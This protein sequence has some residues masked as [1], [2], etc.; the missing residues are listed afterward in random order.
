MPNPSRP[1]NSTTVV[2]SQRPA[3]RLNVIA[4]PSRGGDT[5]ETVRQKIARTVAASNTKRI[6]RSSGRFRATVN[7]TAQGGQGRA[8][9]AGTGQRSE[10]ASTRD[11]RTARYH[12]RHGD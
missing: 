7:A 2:D 4:L 9:R 5:R 3:R 8:R 1:P 10:D 12:A 6:G 11:A